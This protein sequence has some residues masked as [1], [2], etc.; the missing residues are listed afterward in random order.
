MLRR[1]S[2]KSLAMPGR[3]PKKGGS[4]KPHRG[5]KKGVGA[6]RDVEERPVSAIDE[7]DNNDQE[8][9]EKVEGT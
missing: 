9:S 3:R 1:R 8:K 6:S 5:K 2:S 4:S 7:Q